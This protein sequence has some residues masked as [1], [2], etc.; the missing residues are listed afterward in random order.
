MVK[1]FRSHQKILFRRFVNNQRQHSISSVIMLICFLLICVV[2]PPSGSAAS[3]VSQMKPSYDLLSVAFPTRND[4]W[5][6]GRWGTMLHT[7]DGGK[8]WEYQKTGTD[9]TLSSI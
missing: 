8:T 7:A 4:G 3:A 5:A 1:T 6:C 2:A 9:Y